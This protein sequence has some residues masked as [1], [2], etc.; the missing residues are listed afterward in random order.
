MKKYFL[1]A[2]C[3]FSLH[4]LSAQSADELQVKKILADQT[5]AWNRGNIDDFM[6]GYWHND[7]LMY[8]GKSGISYGYKNTLENY[9]KNYNSPEKMGKLFFTLLSVKRL[10]PSYYFVTGKWFLKRS[11]GDVGGYYTLL[12]RKINGSWFIITDHSS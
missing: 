5:E 8:V 3:L 7:S 11:A 9:K 2:I 4:T 12:F 6:K 10:S 1:V